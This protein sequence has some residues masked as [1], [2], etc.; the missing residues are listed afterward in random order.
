MPRPFRVDAVPFVVYGIF[1]DCSRVRE[2]RSGGN[3]AEVLLTDG[4]RLV[5]IL[6]WLGVVAVILYA[7]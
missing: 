6:L 7:G 2:R 4:P 5:N 1:R 3:P